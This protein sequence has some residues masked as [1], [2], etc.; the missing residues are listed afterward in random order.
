MRLA[1]SRN[2]SST[3]SPV[4]ALVRNIRP[5]GALQCLDGLAGQAPALLQV[6][7]V[8]QQQERDGTDFGRHPGLDRLGDFQRLGPRAVGDQEVTTRAAHIG[9][10]Y[11]VDVVFTG[12]VPTEP[13]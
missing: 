6:G 7:L 9:H 4:F 10:A 8:E 13:A 11:R 12:D 1:N 2:A 5:P 3:F